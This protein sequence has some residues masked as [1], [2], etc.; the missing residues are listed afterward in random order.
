LF[1]WFN[2]HTPIAPLLDALTRP[3]YRIFQR[4]IPSIGNV[5]LSPIFVLIGAQ[6]LL[7]LIGDL[8][9]KF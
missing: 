1:S 8:V 7:F 2:P 3:F 4:F 5:D 6:V 9:P